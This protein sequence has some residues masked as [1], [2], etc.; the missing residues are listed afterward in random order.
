MPQCRRALHRLKVSL[1]PIVKLNGGRP[2]PDDV[3]QGG[4]LVADGIILGVGLSL[5]ALVA[6]TGD[7][8]KFGRF[9]RKA[10]MFLCPC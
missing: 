3:S 9:L 10:S 1:L 4:S 2:F 8:T 7:A 5:L 6:M